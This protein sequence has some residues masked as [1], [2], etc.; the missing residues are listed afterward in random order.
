[1]TMILQIV[2]AVVDMIDQTSRKRRADRSTISANLI[3]TE[4]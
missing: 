1:M 3:E 2:F 4:I